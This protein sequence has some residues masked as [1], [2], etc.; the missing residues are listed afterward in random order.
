MRSILL[1]TAALCTAALAGCD[2]E[3]SVGADEAAVRSYC[4]YDPVSAN[5]VPACTSN[6]CQC[7]PALCGNGGECQVDIDC[8]QIK[9]ACQLCADG[10]EACPRSTC[11]GG[12]CEVV[13]PT[14]P[15][16]ECEKNE[17]CPQPDAPC[18]ACADGS[19][20][21]YQGVCKD[22][23]CAVE[24]TECPPATCKEPTMCPPILCLVACPY[25]SIPDAN[26]CETCNCRKETDPKPVPV[27]GLC[28]PPIDS[29]ITCS[30]GSQK[31][32]EAH[33]VDGACKVSYPSCSPPPQCTRNDQCPQLGIACKLCLDGSTACPSSW[34]GADGLCH[35]TTPSCQEPKMCGGFAGLP[36]PSTQHCIDDPRDDCDPK[37]GGAD[38]SGICVNGPAT[39]N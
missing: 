10:T 34:C 13:L 25:G 5:K 27:P 12:K 7:D 38:C 29:C 17:Q 14:C 2:A 26:G 6:D 18:L 1:I 32:A 28:A 4:C 35:N 16:K 39:N 33:C 15:P 24:K 3:H 8:P 22:G 23:H 9:I 30:D 21:G 31:C 20:A 19:C 36:C 11:N 37:N